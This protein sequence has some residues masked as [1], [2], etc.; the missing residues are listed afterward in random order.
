[1]VIHT[2]VAFIIFNR[3]E[4]TER[5]FQAIRQARPKKLLVIAD[6]S[7]IDRPDEVE[8]CS[9]ARAVIDQVDWECEV[10]TNYSATN[11]GC[12]RRVASG[13]DWV[14]SQVE[15]AIILE[16]DCLPNPSFFKYCQ[17]L[18]EHYRYDERIWCISGNNF[19][20]GQ[21][22][23]SG[24]Y[25]F[26]NYN[27][28][29]GWAS[30]RRAWQHYDHNLSHW[31]EVRDGRY[32]TGILD[33]DLEVQFWQ[34]VFENIYTLG[35]PNTW[36]YAWTFTCWLNRGLTVL[37]NVNLVSNIG[38]GLNATH[39]LKRNRFSNLPTE[40]IGKIHH[41]PFIIRHSEA[42]IYIADY[43][44]STKRRW[45]FKLISYKMCYKLSKIFS[46]QDYIKNESS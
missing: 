20:D 12:K 2:P 29:W 28:C 32:L 25:Y 13:I 22:R 44:V 43:F 35:E 7:R 18:L 14:F 37:P 8:M 34:D 15:E 23:G 9:T 42:D 17:E 27:H 30:W 10:L 46:K 21:Q 36:D 41:P 6:G 45:P 1:V 4:L 38:F 31:P 3:P 19:Q 40:E 33:S 11:L 24:S 26:S 16:D 39:T 5:V